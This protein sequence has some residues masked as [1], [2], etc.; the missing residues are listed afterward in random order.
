[1]TKGYTLG[2]AGNDKNKSKIS[3]RLVRSELVVTCPTTPSHNSQVG[4]RYVYG[5]WKI[6][7]VLLT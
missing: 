5:K 4:H 3:K 7:R 6:Q 2:P 1:M